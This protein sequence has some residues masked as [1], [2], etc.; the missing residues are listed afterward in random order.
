MPQFRNPCLN[1]LHL[2]PAQTRTRTE[3]ELPNSY[4]KLL[5]YRHLIVRFLQKMR[6]WSRSESLQLITTL[7][8][9]TNYTS[10][11]YTDHPQMNTHCIEIFL[12][13]TIFEQLVLALKKLSCPEIFHCI[14]YT[15][16]IQDFWATCACPENRVCPENFQ[17]RGAAAPLDPPPRTPMSL[18]F[19]FRLH[20]PDL[21]ANYFLSLSHCQ[22]DF[23]R[24]SL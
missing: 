23:S 21:N 1:T 10:P 14:E 18:K 7:V 5:N 17:A 20:I 19:E 3:I 11:N 9:I 8:Q 4:I 13:F 24:S 16:Y 6:A 12:P 15:F 22:R 2:Y